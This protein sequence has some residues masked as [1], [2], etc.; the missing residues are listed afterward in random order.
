VQFSDLEARNLINAFQS[1]DLLKCPKCGSDLT[2]NAHA[3]ITMLRERL[4]GRR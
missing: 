4:E 1:G 3:T 2:G